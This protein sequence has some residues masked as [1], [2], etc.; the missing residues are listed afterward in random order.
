MLEKQQEKAKKEQKETK[1]AEA[2]AIN[3]EWEE[4]YSLYQQENEKAKKKG[5]VICGGFIKRK[6]NI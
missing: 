5:R 4:L 6:T 1:Q 2:L 3:E